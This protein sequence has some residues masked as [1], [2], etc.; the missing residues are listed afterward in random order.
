[1]A[2]NFQQLNFYLLAIVKPL[3]PLPQLLKRYPCRKSEAIKFW[4]VVGLSTSESDSGV[5]VSLTL[6]RFPHHLCRV[7]AHL[8][9]R[10]WMERPLHIYADVGDYSI[11]SRLS[12]E[13]TRLILKNG[14]KPKYSKFERRCFLSIS[15]VNVHAA[16][17]KQV[18]PGSRFLGPGA[19]PG[20]QNA[21][22]KY[23]F[24]L[25]G[26]NYAISSYGNE[27]TRPPRC[28]IG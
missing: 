3:P 6:R 28:L 5:S 18:V 24:D 16:V 26:M 19:S 12:I 15:S 10:T 27:I 11:G 7:D 14:V 9:V 20:I 22:V 25:C 21:E 8:L 4:V 2:S 13:R 17:L 23:P 1:V